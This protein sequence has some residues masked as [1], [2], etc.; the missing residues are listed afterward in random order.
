MR[1]PETPFAGKSVH[2]DYDYITYVL[3]QHPGQWAELGE[4]DSKIVAT[5]GSRFRGRAGRFFEFK[6]SSLGHGSGRSML[7]GRYVGD[8]PDCQPAGTVTAKKRK[9]GKKRKKK[10][11]A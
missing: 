2:Y 4:N 9:K 7:Y 10:H 11:A 3:K 8:L 6:V 5:Y 1:F